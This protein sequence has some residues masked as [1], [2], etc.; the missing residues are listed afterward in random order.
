MVST[1]EEFHCI[2]SQSLVY[3][4]DTGTELYPLCYYHFTHSVYEIGGLVIVGERLLYAHDK[5][6]GISIPQ[7]PP[8]PMKCIHSQSSFLPWKV[9]DMY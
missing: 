5:G 2:K 3:I 8:S 6:T 7:L 4:A 9:C 1:L